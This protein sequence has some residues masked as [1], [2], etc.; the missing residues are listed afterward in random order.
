MASGRL[1]DYLGKGLASARP[2]SLDLH[3]EAVGFWYATDTDELSAWDGSAWID[4]L[5][6]GGIPDAPSDGTTYGRKDGAWSA[7]ATVTGVAVT[8]KTASATL[9]LSDGDWIE[10][11][12]ATANNLTVPP[13][14]SVAFPVGTVRNVNQRGAGQT[15]IVAG[16]G[17]TVRTDETLKLRKQWATAVLVKRAA[18]EWV[19]AGSLEAAP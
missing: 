11:D 1:A 6:G 9:A 15:T 19:L 13:N 2:A 18:D 17:V 5:S 8:T 3:P 14:S 10:M 4:G 16:A 12:V 7:V